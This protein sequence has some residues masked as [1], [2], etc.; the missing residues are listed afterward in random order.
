MRTKP[1]KPNDGQNGLVSTVPSSSVKLFIAISSPPPGEDI[2]A[3]STDPLRADEPALA[4]IANWGPA[5][6][7]ADWADAR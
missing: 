2:D 1:P 4:D 7:W 5:E 3:W 6:D